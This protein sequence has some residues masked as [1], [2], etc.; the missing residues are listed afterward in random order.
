MFS[1]M[2]V[3]SE[4]TVCLHSTPEAKNLQF[5]YTTEQLLEFLQLLNITF[6]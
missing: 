4:H 3:T 1:P 6:S 2:Q 5:N